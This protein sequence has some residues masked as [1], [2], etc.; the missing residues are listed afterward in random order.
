MGNNRGVYKIVSSR[1]FTRQLAAQMNACTLLVTS[2]IMELISILA[3]DSSIRARIRSQ[4]DAKCWWVPFQHLKILWQYA[5]CLN[6]NI[7]TCEM[8]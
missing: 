1:K 5:A 7:S 4:R 3:P 6:Q 8:N 2:T